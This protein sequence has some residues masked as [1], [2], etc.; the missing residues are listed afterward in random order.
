M[1]CLLLDVNAPIIG[2]DLSEQPLLPCGQL[3]ARVRFGADFL[4]ELALAVVDFLMATFFFTDVLFLGAVFAR[5][6]SF[7]EVDLA[8]TFVA[9]EVFFTGML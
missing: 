8:F 2:D 1:L 3:R 6:V 9:P 5:E 4:R 7:F